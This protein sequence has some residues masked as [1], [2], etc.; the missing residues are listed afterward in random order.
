MTTEERIDALERRLD[1]ER[2]E[3]EAL[4]KIVLVPLDGVRTKLDHFTGR[5]EELR[6]RRAASGA[7]DASSVED[8]TEL[9]RAVTTLLYL[10][11]DLVEGVNWLQKA[12][13]RELQQQVKLTTAALAA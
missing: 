11:Y 7:D 3:R 4:Q 5:L 13:L 10:H 12:F 8:I 2:A 6:L 9:Y 1:T